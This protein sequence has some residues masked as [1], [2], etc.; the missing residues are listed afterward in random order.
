MSN[1]NYLIPLF[2]FSDYCGTSAITP[3][4]SLSSCERTEKERIIQIDVYSMT[5]TISL[6]ESPESELYCY[7]YAYAINKALCEDV[8][9]GGIVNSAIITS[10][11]V[12]PP[13]VARCGMSWDLILTL[14]ITVEGISK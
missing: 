5:I 3:V 13:K 10:E 12:V 2:E 11:K 4:I 9:F 14:R 8:T 1:W 6:P 7:G